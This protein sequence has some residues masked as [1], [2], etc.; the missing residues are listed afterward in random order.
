M[1][2]LEAQ[3]RP[4]GSRARCPLCREDLAGPVFECPGCATHYHAGCA[5]FLS[6]CST[7]GC[8]RK[9]QPVLDVDRRARRQGRRA[10]SRLVF[11]GLMAALPGVGLTVAY[12]MLMTMWKNT[13]LRRYAG[14][15]ALVEQAIARHEARPP[16]G[17]ERALLREEVIGHTL[18]RAWEHER[19]AWAHLAGSRDG[20]LERAAREREARGQALRRA[21][22]AA[23]VSQTELAGWVRAALGGIPPGA[24]GAV[25]RAVT[26]E[27]GPPDGEP[28]LGSPLQR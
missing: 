25:G 17:E 14:R 12:A 16:A 22:G 4:T 5:R 20:H 13:E 23:G 2:E 19:L 10:I 6:G 3:L 26:A 15:A 18:Q 21:L 9:G 11:M 8:P 24:R 1:R 28:L 27:L 7:L